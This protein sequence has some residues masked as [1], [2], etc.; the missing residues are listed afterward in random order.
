MLIVG[1][2]GG[3]AILRAGGAFDDRAGGAFVVRVFTEVAGGGAFVA[4][5]RAGGTDVRF[6]GALDARE[7][8]GGD[9]APGGKDLGEP[10]SSQ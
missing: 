7:V 10:G 1:G 3:G 9:D 8:F 5:A 6:S 4:R 2:R